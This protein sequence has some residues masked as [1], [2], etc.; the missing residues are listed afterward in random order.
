MVSLVLAL[1]LLH[2]SSKV[3]S[4]QEELITVPRA[5]YT[6]P[7]LAK[8]LSTPLRLVTVAKNIKSRG[9]VVCLKDRSWKSTQ[10]ILSRALDVRIRDAT[11]V[12]K[13]WIMEVD[14]NVAERQRKWLTTISKRIHDNIQTQLA[15]SHKDFD[16]RLTYGEYVRRTVELDA[17][18][19]DVSKDDPDHTKPENAKLAEEYEN[20][21]EYSNFEVWYSMHIGKSIGINDILQAM[22]APQ[23]L[24]PI[25]FRTYYDAEAMK[26][27]AAL[28]EAETATQKAAAIVAGEKL[29]PKEEAQSKLDQAALTNPNWTGLFRL[30]FDPA[31][32]SVTLQLLT[33]MSR[34][35]HIL[36]VVSGTATDLETDQLPS[37]FDPDYKLWLTPLKQSTA[38]FL[39]S[40]T[41]KTPIPVNQGYPTTGVSQLLESLSKTTGKEVVQEI[42]VYRDNVSISG[43]NSDAT[44]NRPARKMEEAVTFQQAL[45]RTDSDGSWL[46]ET[47]DDVVIAKNQRAF[48]DRLAPVPLAQLLTLEK[49]SKAAVIYSDFRAIPSLNDVINF[50]SLVTSMENNTLLTIPQFRGLHLYEIACGRPILNLI[51]KLNSEQL[52]KVMSPDKAKIPLSLFAVGVLQDTITLMRE[53]ALSGHY[54]DTI[55]GNFREEFISILSK[56]AI[57]IESNDQKGAKSTNFWV[58]ETGADQDN[59]S[60]YYRFTLVGTKIP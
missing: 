15:E 5:V 51:S 56:M 16:P 32:A 22:A 33:S 2:H 36:T 49:R 14:P 24:K 53:L 43:R 4:S 44:E 45:T 59:A 50:Q 28:M 10:D 20:L 40:K 54:Y 30:Q 34:F 57:S 46:F 42:D 17:K 11:G 27:M 18:L 1:S 25:D 12:G 7:E 23:P 60:G 48:L 39:D 8:K 13:T 41:A 9:A 52:N 29:D 26:A 55:D 47:I 58:V 38:N 35:N 31:E 19:K 6:Y 21:S 37:D 3:I